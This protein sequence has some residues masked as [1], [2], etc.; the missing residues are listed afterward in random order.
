MV[1]I[2]GINE[3]ANPLLIFAPL[4]LMLLSGYAIGRI[5]FTV[6][7]IKTSFFKELLYGNIILTFIFISGFIVFGFLISSANLY[8]TI[9][10]YVLIAFTSVGTYLIV[11]LQV[12]TRPR[13]RVLMRLFENK[14]VTFGVGLFYL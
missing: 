7:K 6:S 14:H 1:I 13:K 10:T 8:F 11:K 5:I 12:A 4:V 3:V 9:F 2:N